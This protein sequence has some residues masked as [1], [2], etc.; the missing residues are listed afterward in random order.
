MN[1]TRILI[2]LALIAICPLLYGQEVDLRKRLVL[3]RFDSDAEI[4]WVRYF[5]GYLDHRYVVDL[6][7]ASDGQQVHGA[8]RIELDSIVFYLDG[9]EEDGRLLLDE[10]DEDGAEIAFLVGIFDGLNFDGHWKN[11]RGD[12]QF[13]LQFSETKQFRKIEGAKP[14]L[15]S[16]DTRVDGF[17]G[18]WSL[19]C[20]GGSYISGT[21]IDDVN[22]WYQIR[23]AGRQDDLWKILIVHQQGRQVYQAFL[24]LKRNRIYLPGVSDGTKMKRRMDFPVFSFRKFT[25]YSDFHCA[26]EVNKEY[27]RLKLFVDSTFQTDHPEMLESE[28][29][30]RGHALK[31]HFVNPIYFDHNWLVFQWVMSTYTPETGHIYED[32]LVHFRLD[33]MEVMPFDHWWIENGVKDIPL[34]PT[35]KQ[36][37]QDFEQNQLW[38]EP[39]EYGEYLVF[40]RL[41]YTPKGV[42]FTNQYNTVV[43]SLLVPVLHF[44]IRDWVDAKLAKKGKK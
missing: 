42:H 28:E 8:M 12:I 20:D 15:F 44:E 4:K 40:D 35:F 25:T 29:Q 13:T 1:Y 22:E 37:L 39:A 26:L 24:D 27:R 10:T 34:A 41:V 38:F 5:R 31:Q 16:F 3:E 19:Y 7:L 18:H 11:K 23:P 21:Y 6:L 2:S 9:V 32:F 33:K 36:F 43:G 14:S 17:N 30:I